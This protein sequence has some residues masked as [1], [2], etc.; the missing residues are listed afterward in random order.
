MASR[1]QINV[2]EEGETPTKQAE[3]RL[4]A[5]C[6]EEIG[7][8]FPINWAEYDVKVVYDGGVTIGVTATLTWTRKANGRQFFLEDVLFKR[9]GE[10]IEYYHLDIISA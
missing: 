4:I 1:A 5:E 9:T 10:M 7:Q 8:V 2:L 3:E 6:Q